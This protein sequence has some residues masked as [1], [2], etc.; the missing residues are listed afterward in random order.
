LGAIGCN[1]SVTSDP[2]PAAKKPRLGLAKN[3][4]DA[5]HSVLAQNLCSALSQASEQIKKQG[6]PSWWLDIESLKPQGSS[7]LD[8]DMALCVEKLDQDCERYSAGLTS[9]ASMTWLIRCF[10]EIIRRAFH[11]KSRAN[12]RNHKKDRHNREQRFRV[13]ELIIAITRPLHARYGKNA[14][15]LY[16]LL[17][18]KSSTVTGIVSLLTLHERRNREFWPEGRALEELFKNRNAQFCFA[19]R[20]NA[21]QTAIRG[22][23]EEN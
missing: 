13:G 8:V 22:L 20:K 12:A 9:R 5:H 21:S 16:A 1:E 15:K 17:A 2:G 11:K 19:D 3:D 4:R 6:A 14:Y 18:G 7:L 10:L 23:L